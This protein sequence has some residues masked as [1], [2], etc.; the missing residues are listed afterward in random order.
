[1]NASAWGSTIKSKPSKSTVPVHIGA[2]QDLIL[3][4]AQPTVRLVKCNL[5]DFTSF[6]YLNQVNTNSMKLHSSLRHKMAAILNG[7]DLIG[8]SWW[9]TY[10]VGHTWAG[11]WLRHG[12]L[13]LRNGKAYP[14]FLLKFCVNPISSNH[15][16]LLW[17][18][19]TPLSSE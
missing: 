7:L 16:S 1:M 10:R 6:Y 3:K 8:G 11:L 18:K 12:S 5:D 14:L 17:Q 4:L 19:K 13:S 15:D 2:E 9:W